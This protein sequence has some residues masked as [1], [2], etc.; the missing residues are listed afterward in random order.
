M[1]PSRRSLGGAV[2]GPLPKEV[3]PM[4]RLNP[5]LS[6]RF[7]LQ[8]LS[9]AALVAAVGLALGGCGGSDSPSTVD[10]DPA[11]EGSGVFLAT[12]GANGQ[13]AVVNDSGEVVLVVET[14]DSLGSPIPDLEITYLES[15][16]DPLI[17]FNDGDGEPVGTF[18]IEGGAAMKGEPVPALSGVFILSLL[19]PTFGRLYDTDNDDFETGVLNNIETIRSVIDWEDLEVIFAMTPGLTDEGIKTKGEMMATPHTDGVLRSYERRPGDLYLSYYVQRIGVFSL[20][21]ENQHDHYRYRHY[22]YKNSIGFLIPLGL[23]VAVLIVEPA[24]GAVFSSAADREQE[25]WGTLDV[26]P[27]VVTSAGGQLKLLLNGAAMGDVLELEEDGRGGSSF[28]SSALLELPSGETTIEIVAYVSETN[29]GFQSAADGL[30]GSATSRVRYTGQLE[31]PFAPVLSGLSHPTSYPC[32]DMSFVIGFDYTDPDAD[33]A[34]LY[35]HVTTSMGGGEEEDLGITAFAIQGDPGIACLKG[36]SGR[37]EFN[38]HYEDADGGYMIRYEFW[39]VDAQG[40]ESNHL[41]VQVDVTG[42]C[43]PFGK[44]GGGG[45]TLSPPRFCR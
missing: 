37:C 22:K 8:G 24:D 17:S 41:T 29:R 20:L 27:D 2:M 33:G 1:A 36:T 34:T 19:D 6:G 4:Q 15:D 35:M 26:S 31:G 21:A 44:G 45:F 7:R 40:H 32:P 39:V 42:D 13:A 3:S 16:P 9:L 14:L 43:D 11:A 5:G 10:D 12:T 28:S 18:L 23:E 25:I 38:A 30:A